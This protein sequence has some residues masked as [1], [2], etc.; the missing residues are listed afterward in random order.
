MR[1]KL[2][3][4]AAHASGRCLVGHRTGRRRRLGPGH[5]R[6]DFGRRR[7]EDR[8]GG[9][10]GA[11]QGE[12]DGCQS[13]SQMDRREF[14]RLHDV[15]GKFCLGCRSL[16]N[17]PLKLKR[18]R[19][20]SGL[21]VARLLRMRAR[22]VVVGCSIDG[23]TCTTPDKAR[24]PEPCGV[25][26]SWSLGSRKANRDY[27]PPEPSSGQWCS[28]N[29]MS[30]RS[31]SRMNLRVITSGRVELEWRASTGAKRQFMSVPPRRVGCNGADAWTAR[32]QWPGLGLQGRRRDI[33]RQPP[34]SEMDPRNE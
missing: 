19:A 15:S 33:D 4:S 28:A 1:A 30:F 9:S 12:N 16:R 23:L 2:P 3:R 27:D 29:R 11:D 25:R 13:C 5:R 17:R 31:V 10:Q 8:C 7:S 24:G 22:P 32:W 20:S 6:I 14:G 34:R 21:R 26:A 18:H